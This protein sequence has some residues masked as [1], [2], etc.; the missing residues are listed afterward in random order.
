MMK[1]LK[2]FAEGALRSLKAWKWVLVIWFSFLMLALIVSTPFK[3]EM[4]TIIGRSMITEKIAEGNI[5]DFISNSVTGLRMAMASLTSVFFLAVFLALILNSFFSAGL[6]HIL[7]S[8]DKETPGVSFFGKAG[9]GFFSFLVIEILMKLMILIVILLVIGLPV[10]LSAG[11]SMLPDPGKMKIP[12]IL[13]SIL[14]PVLLMVADFSRAWLAATGSKNPFR[15]I[16]NGFR[17]AFR[18]FFSSWIIMAILI[19]IQGLFSWITI[20][21]TRALDPMS[22][23]GIFGMFFLLQLLFIARF[24]LRTWRYGSITAV[25]E[26]TRE[27]KPVIAAETVAVQ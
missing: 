13:V 25:F 1:I 24:F 3:A 10:S 27:T 5:V 23:W 18:S 21:V 9:S 20:T 2:Y 8:G 17:F 12:V 4:R 16:G 19:L 15:A 14:L 6:F 26:S 22:V 7:R 11:D